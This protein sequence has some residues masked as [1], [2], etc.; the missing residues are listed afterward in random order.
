MFV[1]APMSPKSYIELTDAIAAAIAGPKVDVQLGPAGVQWC[2]KPLL[3]A[4]AEKFPPNGRP[5]P[6]QLLQTISP[7]PLADPRFSD[8][9]VPHLRQPRFPVQALN[10]APSH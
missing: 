6:V 2:S 3:E 1:R 4:V 10:P 5:I 8:G 7:P 9:I